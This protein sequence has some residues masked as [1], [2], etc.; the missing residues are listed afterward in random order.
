LTAE[1]KEVKFWKGIVFL[2][3]SDFN[4]LIAKRI[5]ESQKANPWIRLDGM[6]N[7]LSGF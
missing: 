3:Y 4:H 2:N 1:R 7:G 5:G 6:G